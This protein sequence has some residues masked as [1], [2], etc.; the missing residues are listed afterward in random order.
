MLTAVILIKTLILEILIGI[1]INQ[2][3][4]HIRNMKILIGTLWDRA[5]LFLVLAKT[6]RRLIGAPSALKWIQL[7]QEELVLLMRNRKSHPWKVVLS[8]WY[9]QLKGRQ[10]ALK[11][12]R[13]E[14]HKDRHQKVNNIKNC[15]LQTILNRN[16]IGRI[17]I[18]Q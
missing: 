10:V 11:L 2:L 3:F 6:S 9:L 14:A 7:L 18:I 8:R 13:S 16:F 15:Q 17:L 1:I 5:L 12:L 4:L